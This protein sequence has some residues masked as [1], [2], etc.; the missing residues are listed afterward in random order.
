MPRI[1][2]P[3]DWC[4]ER[5]HTN[6]PFYTIR[7]NDGEMLCMYRLRPEGER[8]GTDANPAYV[9]Y[10]LGDDLRNTLQQIGQHPPDNT[11]I[12][13]SWNT[14]RQDSMGAGPFNTDVTNYNLK[15]HNWADEHW[16]LDGTTNGSTIRLL[17]TIRALPQWPV[18]VTCPRL[19]GIAKILNTNYIQC[20][21]SDS[22][23]ARDSIYEQ[24]QFYAR[25]GSPTFLWCAGGGL[26]PTAYKLFAN[27]P[28]TT[29]IDL[30]HLFNGYYGIHDYG[31]LTHK[32]GPW[33]KPYFEEFVPWLKSQ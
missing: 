14:P 21:A 10:G 7:I 18:L 17:T 13:C 33:Y 27:Y 26:K 9:R 1:T 24:C 23:I 3:V 28:R 6:T 20:P 2:T 8:L 19:A 30:G 12:G 11:L 5:L 22:Y 4:I 15:A 25:Q 31:W 16:P 29:H 32:T